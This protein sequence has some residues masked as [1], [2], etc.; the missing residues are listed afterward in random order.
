MCALYN[1][2]SVLKGT[3]I[4]EHLTV[5]NQASYSCLKASVSQSVENHITNWRHIGRQWLTDIAKTLFGV[6]IFVN[7]NIPSYCMTVPEGME[8]IRK[9]GGVHEIYYLFKQSHSTL[10]STGHVVTTVS[11]QLTSVMVVASSSANNTHAAGTL[12]NY[13]YYICCTALH[14]N[15]TKKL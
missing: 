2:C 12:H 5:K 14:R 15:V 1:F 11:T 6:P 10:T 8:Y 13:K 3:S 9:Q 4:G 7:L